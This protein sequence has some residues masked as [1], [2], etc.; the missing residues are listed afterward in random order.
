MTTSHTD[1]VSS[2][3]TARTTDIPPHFVVMTPAVPFALALTT[4]VSIH[5]PFRP[6]GKVPHAL[7]P[8]SIT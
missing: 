4:L 5:V 6:A 7:T 8:R 3:T 1:E 2:V